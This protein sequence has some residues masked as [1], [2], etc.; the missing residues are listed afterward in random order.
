MSKKQSITADSTGVSEMIAAHAGVRECLMVHE[1]LK[2]NGEPLLLKTDNNVVV[3][4]SRRGSSD[5]LDY[6][7]K[8]PFSIRLCL[9]RD[10][11]D[12]GVMETEYV[13]T[14]KNLADGFTKMMMVL[15]FQR[16]RDMMNVVERDPERQLV[17]QIENLKILASKTA[18]KNGK[19]SRYAVR[20]DMRVEQ[21]RAMRAANAA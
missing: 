11:R 21:L 2:P 13:E 10:F 19:A 12:Y 8:R 1:C 14:K 9:L 15:E 16:C 3:R 5:K 6:I 20:Y 18:G 17:K 4:I 7:E